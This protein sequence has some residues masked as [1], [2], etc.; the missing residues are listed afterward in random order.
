MDVGGGEGTEIVLWMVGIWE[1][2]V[3]IV[4][5]SVDGVDIWL[6]VGSVACACVCNRTNMYVVGREV[7]V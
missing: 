7:F 2:R 4:D 3:G 5:G 6:S 1:R